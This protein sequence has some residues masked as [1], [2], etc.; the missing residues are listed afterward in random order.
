MPMLLF[1]ILLLSQATGRSL[2]VLVLIFISLSLH[3][4]VEL[5]DILI[6]YLLLGFSIILFDFRCL[7]Y[8]LYIL[9]FT[10]PIATT[11]PGQ[12]NARCLAFYYL[13]LN[14]CR[15]HDCHS[16]PLFGH[17]MVG[18]KRKAAEPNA[19]YMLFKIFE[20][21][22]EGHMIYLFAALYA[23]AILFTPR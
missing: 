13:I 21:Q 9:S 11:T 18:P 10:R 23:D 8:I 14:I 7:R 15:R 20:R 12:H 2:L 4:L 3:I 1:L 19:P 17:F 5:H 16:T 6:R 22:F